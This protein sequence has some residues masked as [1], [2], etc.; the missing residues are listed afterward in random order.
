[1]SRTGNVRHVVLALEQSR[2]LS[3]RVY[4]TFMIDWPPL[5]VSLNLCD[6]ASKQAA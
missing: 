4:P 3:R 1:M 2:R 6:L 5:T